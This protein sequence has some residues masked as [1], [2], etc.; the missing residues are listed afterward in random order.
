MVAIDVHMSL[1]NVGA[2]QYNASS[3]PFD[4]VFECT[5]RVARWHVL[6]E[7]VIFYIVIQVGLEILIDFPINLRIWGV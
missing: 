1:S 7:I 3:V 5:G 4:A 6:A 2:A